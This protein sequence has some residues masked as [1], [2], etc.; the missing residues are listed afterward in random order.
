MQIILKVVRDNRGQ[1]SMVD[2]YLAQ[3]YARIDSGDVPIDFPPFEGEVVFAWDGADEFRDNSAGQDR[4]PLGSF[5][6]L[7]SLEK[8]NAQFILTRL[9]PMILKY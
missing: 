3:F 5:K 4:V 2:D 6:P 9:N 1:A 8:S 7:P